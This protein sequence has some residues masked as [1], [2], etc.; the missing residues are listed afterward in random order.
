MKNIKVYFAR[1]DFEKPVL[2]LN[3][4]E[5]KDLDLSYDEGKM[6]FDGNIENLF[7]TT[8]YSHSIYRPK[9]GLQYSA[10]C[11][12]KEQAAEMALKEHFSDAPEVTSEDI[13]PELRSA[14]LVRPFLEPKKFPIQTTLY[15]GE[16]GLFCRLNPHPELD[17]TRGR[18]KVYF[19][20]RSCVN[21]LR[22]GP[23]LITE[24]KDMGSYGFFKGR[25]RKFS[26]PTDDDLDKWIENFY[27][28]GG[29]EG[30][31][32]FVEG[33]LGSYV[34]TPLDAVLM[35]DE[36]GAFVNN[37]FHSDFGCEG[38][39]TKTIS[40]EDYL[41]EGYHD[42]KF[43]ELAQKFE[44]F[45]LKNYLENRMIDYFYVY[46]SNKFISEL[47]DD[48]VNSGFLLP[49]SYDGVFFVL[50]DRSALAKSLTS[51]SREEMKELIKTVNEINRKAEEAIKSKIKNGKIK[52]S[53]PRTRLHY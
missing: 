2:C 37:F 11:T 38:T 13:L 39:V 20:D 30:N 41:C 29:R 26:F 23:V 10:W 1:P 19:P 40:F 5:A 51:Y 44:A 18:G 9:E 35:R 4:G 33:S 28:H 34:L 22:E 52:I 43:D 14:T 47:F 12:T 48:A 7:D 16:K 3:P 15:R 53:E 32:R 25:M 31:F 46:Q 24:V 45:S 36:N 27:A 17:G 6:I 21:Q 42:C 50:L 8:L 49:R